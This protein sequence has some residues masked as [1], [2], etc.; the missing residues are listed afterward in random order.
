M[1]SVQLNPST[2]RVVGVGVG[3]EL[4]DASA[5]ILFQSFS[6]GGR[7]EQFRHRRNGQH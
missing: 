3:E 4:G 2:D 7:R 5:D 1:S 6:A